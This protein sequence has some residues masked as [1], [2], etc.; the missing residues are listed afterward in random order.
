M[1]FHESW[2]HRQ[3][4]RQKVCIFHGRLWIYTTHVMLLTQSCEVKRNQ[5]TCCSRSTS[6]YK[7]PPLVT[8][9]YKRISIL[10]VSTHNTHVTILICIC[11]FPLNAS[12]RFCMGRTQRQRVCLVVPR[13]TKWTTRYLQTT[14]DT[15]TLFTVYLLMYQ[16]MT[17]PRPL[18]K[19][20]L[21]RVW[22][23]A[24]YMNFQYPLVSLRSSCSCLHLLPRIPA[25][26]IPPSIL[27]SITCFR[28]QFLHKT[29]PT[30]L[31]VLIFIVCRIFFPSLLPCNIS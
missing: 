19:R 12:E 14:F 15:V 4:Y 2:K 1:T 23:R 28:R 16:L 7:W 10:R 11:Q 27:P 18:P 20:I 26:C 30:Q 5:V 25:T 24:S 3:T 13:H 9:Y 8:C 17:D 29:W 22:P 21:H 31:T 6:V